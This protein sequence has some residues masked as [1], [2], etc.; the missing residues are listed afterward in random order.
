MPTRFQ[1][2][3]LINR[4]DLHQYP[5]V[6]I[7]NET[8]RMVNICEEHIIIEPKVSQLFFIT[9]YQ[10]TSRFFYLD[11]ASLDDMVER[12]VGCRE[13]EIIT[14]FLDFKY[15][16]LTYGDPA[17]DQQKEQDIYAD[18]PD[19]RAMQLVQHVYPMMEDII[20]A[21]ELID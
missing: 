8:P 15:I 2:Y 12:H 6:G 9:N 17:G 7:S 3:I 19:E 5:Y 1:L 20:K 10:L 11:L 16:T 14:R 18:D 21:A 13:Y 4:N